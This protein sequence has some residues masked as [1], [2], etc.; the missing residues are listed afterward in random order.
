MSGRFV[1]GENDS[2]QAQKLKID[3]ATGKLLVESSQS[4]EYA[5]GVSALKI[6]GVYRLWFPSDLEDTKSSPKAIWGIDID[7]FPQTTGL[8]TFYISSSSILDI[9]KLIRVSGVDE[10]F[11]EQFGYA[12]T[13]GRTQVEIVDSPSGGQPIQFIHINSTINLDSGLN[14][15][16]GILY[17]SENAIGGLTNGRPNDNSLIHDFIGLSSTNYFP[18]AT[19]YGQSAKGSIFF[20]KSVIDRNNTRHNVTNIFA[21][22]SVSFIRAGYRIGVELE[23]FEPVTINKIQKLVSI[24][25]QSTSTV[26]SNNLSDGNSFFRFDPGTKISIYANMDSPNSSIGLLLNLLYLP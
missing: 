19:S 8:K 14:P 25:S 4:L 16:I 24:S 6:P 3:T 26:V 15:L 5:M 2:G 18:I 13:N 7:T 23:I 22:T 10:N 17:I 9:G 12:T 21:L 11:D 20:T 1:L